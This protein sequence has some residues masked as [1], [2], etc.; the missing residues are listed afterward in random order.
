MV[1]AV[2]ACNAMGNVVENGKILAGTR[3]DDNT[4]FLDGETWLVENRTRQLDVFSGKFVGEN[5]VIGCVMTNAAL[6]KGQANKTGPQPGKTGGVAHESSPL[7][8]FAK[9]FQRSGEK[10]RRAS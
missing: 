8:K 5:A 2:V 7:L 10:S 3:N 4:A 9:V 6:N 1:G